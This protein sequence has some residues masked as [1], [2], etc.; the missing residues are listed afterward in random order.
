MTFWAKYWPITDLFWKTG[1]YNDQWGFTGWYFYTF[2]LLQNIIKYIDNNYLSDSANIVTKLY[3][4]WWF[5]TQPLNNLNLE[6]GIR[7]PYNV[8]FGPKFGR[9]QS[10]ENKIKSAGPTGFVLI[11]I[12]LSATL[13][14]VAQ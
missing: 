5:T 8:F 3:T 11:S 10:G 12:C 6:K 14:G 13:Q 1:H 7:K 9:Y 2:W 4:S